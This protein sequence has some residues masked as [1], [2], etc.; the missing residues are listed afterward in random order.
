MATKIKITIIDENT[1]YLM[2]MSFTLLMTTNKIVVAIIEIM[3]QL[4]I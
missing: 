3:S 4:K 1:T 2:G